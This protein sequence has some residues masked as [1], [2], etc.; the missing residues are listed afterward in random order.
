[1]GRDND[2]KT[3]L[4][5]AAVAIAFGA[6]TIKSG[7]AVLFFNGEARVAAGHYVEFVVWFNF[8]AGFAYIVAG[9]GMLRRATWAVGLAAFIALSTMAVFMAFGVHVVS[10][11]EYEMRTVMAMSVRSL[12]WLTIALLADSRLSQRRKVYP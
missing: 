3:I 5:M 7:G 10:G 4:A 8:F 9:V 11:G 6:L 1:M 2:K 12:V